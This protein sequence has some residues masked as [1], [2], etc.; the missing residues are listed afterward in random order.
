MRNAYEEIVHNTEYR[1][2]RGHFYERA[3][4]G[5]RCLSWL[6][7]VGDAGGGGKMDGQIRSPAPALTEDIDDP[8]KAF[9]AV[10]PVYLETALHAVCVAGHD[11]SNN[12]VMF[13]D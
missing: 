11:R 7:Q 12:L 2:S 3:V 1:L 10:F 6:P 4:Q 8:G 9:A 13:G 5:C